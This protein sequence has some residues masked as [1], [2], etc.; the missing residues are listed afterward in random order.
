[1]QQAA[2]R[3]TKNDFAKYP[4]LKE[5]TEYVKRLDLRLEDLATPGFASVLNRA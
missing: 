4:F 3:F 1:M 2:L 5:T